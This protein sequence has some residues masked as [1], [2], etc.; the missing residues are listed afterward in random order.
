MLTFCPYISPESYCQCSLGKD[1]FLFFLWHIHGVV[2]LMALVISL[3]PPFILKLIFKMLIF[4]S[5]LYL[6][7]FLLP[8]FS[9][10][11][12]LIY[13][14][15]I[16]TTYLTD[17]LELKCTTMPRMYF[18]YGEHLINIRFLWHTYCIIYGIHKSQKKQKIIVIKL[19]MSYVYPQA[20]FFKIVVK[21]I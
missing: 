19:N 21:Y 9:E 14:M 7:Y 11:W 10:R 15:R 6:F 12:F 8:H 1:D 4:E 16:L 3:F 17:F 5:Q 13:K 2:L 20:E 18:A